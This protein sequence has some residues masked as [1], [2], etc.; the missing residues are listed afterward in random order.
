MKSN[1]TLSL[2]PLCAL[3]SAQIHPPV[4]KRQPVTDTY[5]GTSVTDPYRWLE[6][7]TSPETR[8]WIAA[9]NRYSDALLKNQPS[10]PYLKRRLAQMIKIEHVDTPVQRGNR[11]FFSKQRPK[12]E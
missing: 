8:K 4:A 10:R 7:Q 6:N 1:L 3:A 9:E 2:L 11:F 12:D 5:H